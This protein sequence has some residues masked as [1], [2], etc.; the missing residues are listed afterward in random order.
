MKRIIVVHHVSSL[1]GGTKSL[2]DV[3]NMLKD[4]YEVIVCV[5]N[6]GTEFEIEGV[7]V[8]RLRSRVPYSCIFSGHPY[9]VSKEYLNS[10]LSRLYKKAFAK[11]LA[12]LNPDMVIFNTSVTS[13]GA[14]YL[15]AKI[16]KV[17]IDRETNVDKTAIAY[18][19]K[20][21]DTFDLLCFLAEYEKNKFELP[22]QK[23]FVLPD[24]A[25]I[26]EKTELQHGNQNASINILYMGGD[27]RIKGTD[28]LLKAFSL[29]TNSRLKLTI[30]GNFDMNRFSLKNILLRIYNIPMTAFKLRV[31]RSL[32]K[33]KSDNRVVIYDAVQV[34][35]PF[36]EKADIIVFPS[37]SVHQPRPCIEAG[38]FRKPVLISDYNETKEYFIDGYNAILFKHCNPYDLA[39]KLENLASGKYDLNNLGN[40]NF[41][42]SN[43]F[44]NY[45]VIK[46]TFL[47]KIS[48]ILK[49]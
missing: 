6:N 37:T 11:E 25:P 19:K 42:M 17:C 34:V 39:E 31:H 2:V 40:N 38:Y 4:N 41:Y 47:L 33:I 15:D 32:K 22:E 30:I 10:I 9:V 18:Y 26:N 46:Q 8:Y 36:I 24:S 13:I 5:P 27:A 3:A 48:Q 23:T 12:E 7:K 29:T 49:E 28:V 14:K 1:G 45:G 43:T 35:N 20:I 16:K 44:H 21:F